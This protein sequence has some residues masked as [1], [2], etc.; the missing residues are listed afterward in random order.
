MPAVKSLHQESG[1]NSKAEFI[2]GHSFQ[3]VSLLADSPS[4]QVFAIPL[5]SRICEG[6]V[7]RRLKNPRTLLDKLVSLF[8]DVVQ[9]ADVRAILVADA[10]YASKKVIE[11][12]LA[13]GHHLVTR[14]K[15]NSVAYKSAPKPRRKRP[16]RPKFY[17][18]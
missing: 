7:R 16:G 9:A 3:A 11:P 18:T 10:Y 5:I 1:N 2:M 12:L 15:S 14:A 8:M 6:L 17:G 13:A 4:G